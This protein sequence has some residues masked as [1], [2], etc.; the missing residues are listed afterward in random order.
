ML[1]IYCT[2]GGFFIHLALLFVCVDYLDMGLVGVGIST[3]I[4]FFSRYLIAHFLIQR[5]ERFAQYY[6]KN[7]WADAMKDLSTQF[8]FCLK[9]TPLACLPWWGADAFT[10]I[11]SYLST[12]TLAA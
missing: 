9:S 11:A 3:S 1:P 10:L 2:V 4:H 6:N 7:L 5:H 12:E 8:W